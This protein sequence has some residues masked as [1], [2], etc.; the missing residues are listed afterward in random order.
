LEN[1]LRLEVSPLFFIS[2]GID[3]SP[4]NLALG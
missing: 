1:A 4:L 2:L 3:Y